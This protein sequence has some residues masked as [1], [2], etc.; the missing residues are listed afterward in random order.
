MYDFTE[1]LMRCR[2]SSQNKR[3]LYVNKLFV[4][5]NDNSVFS[6]MLFSFAKVKQLMLCLLTTCE[7]NRALCYVCVCD[8]LIRVACHFRRMSILTKQKQVT[9]FVIVICSCTHVINSIVV[10]L[11]LSHF[12]T[13]SSKLSVKAPLKC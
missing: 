5:L 10:E 6:L 8:S 13:T 9:R 12:C 2:E 4:E 3:L 11:F 7:S 1:E